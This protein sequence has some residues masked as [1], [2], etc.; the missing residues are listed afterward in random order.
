MGENGVD[1][2]RAAFLGKNDHFIMEVDNFQTH[3]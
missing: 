1:P 3:L 2:Q